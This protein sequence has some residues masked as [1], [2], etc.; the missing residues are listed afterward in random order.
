MTENSKLALVVS[1]PTSSLYPYFEPLAKETWDSH[2]STLASK[3]DGLGYGY[4]SLIFGVDDSIGKLGSGTNNKIAMIITTNYQ[5]GELD[6][7]DK[8]QFPCTNCKLVCNV[9]DTTICS[10][11]VSGDTLLSENIRM[12]VIYSKPKNDYD[13]GCILQ[14]PTD[15][16]YLNDSTSNSYD[17]LNTITSNILDIMCPM[18]EYTVKI[19]EI[20][21]SGSLNADNKSYTSPFVEILNTNTFPINL[22]EILFEGLVTGTASYD[23]TNDHWLDG[24]YL[25]LY[26]ADIGNVR[27]QDCPCDK[28]DGALCDDAI[29]IPCGSAYR[30]QFDTSMV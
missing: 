6:N 8:P 22:R 28:S 11:D 10:V 29:Y 21:I 27:C 17:S 25:V 7:S 23:T 3:A 4:N 19:T 5:C 14:N 18:D 1:Y 9:N 15:F 20:K 13:F 16:F 2:I 12:L 30:C 26:N 24:T